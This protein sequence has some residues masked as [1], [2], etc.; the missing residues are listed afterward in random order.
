MKT[1]RM[2]L[3]ET[4]AFALGSMFL[5]SFDTSDPKVKNPG[6]QLYTFRKEMLADAKATLKQIASL[7]QLRLLTLYVLRSLVHVRVVPS[8]Q[9]R[10][11]CTRNHADSQSSQS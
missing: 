5:P 10:F 6:I 2:F 9:F 4:G 3:K 11:D 8:C 7:E 1:R